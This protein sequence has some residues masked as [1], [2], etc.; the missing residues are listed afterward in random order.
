M[1][2]SLENAHVIMLGASLGLFILLLPLPR[3]VHIFPSSPVGVAIICKSNSSDL[4]G[5]VGIV[6]FLAVF[7]ISLTNHWFVSFFVA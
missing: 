4:A 6:K 1:S 2:C 5:M 7:K 3:K